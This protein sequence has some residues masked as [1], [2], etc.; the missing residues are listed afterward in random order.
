MAPKEMR[1]C[2]PLAQ[3]LVVI[4]LLTCVCHAIHF[5][6]GFTDK[7]IIDAQ[8]Q[9]VRSRRDTLVKHKTQHLKPAIEIEPIN[10]KVRVAMP[11][12]NVQDL[13]TYANQAAAAIATRFDDF[14]P[15]LL[16]SNDSRLQTSSAA[17]F[18]AAS[19][20]TKVVA[21][22][23]SRIALMAEEATKYFAQG[24]KLTK[25]QITFALPTMD[26]RN[27]VLA[28]QCPLEVDFPCQPRKYRAY[29]GYCNNVQNP[30]WGNAN[31]RYLRFLPPD[32]SDGVSI[33]RQASDG[34]FLPSARDISLA[35]HKDVDNPHLHLTAMAAIWGQLVHNDISHTPQMAGF[36]GQRLRCCGVNLHEFHP[37]CYPIRLPDTDPVN[38]QINIKCQEYVRSGTAPRVG[39]TLGPREQINQVTSFMDGSTIYGSSVEEAND[40]RLFRAGLMKT[41]PGPAGTTKGLLPPDDNII[42]CNTKNKDV[43]CFKAGDV[44]VN[45]H[46]ELTALHVILI[47]EHNRLAEELAVINSH[48]SDETLFQEAR[49]I[50][51]AEMQHITYSEFLPVIL[52]QTIMEKYGLEPEFSGYF[53]G[54]DIN[55]NPG[56]ANSVAA[57]ALRF[58]ASLLP[59]KMGLYRNGRKI[60]EQKMGSSFYAP[61][62]L[63]EPNGLD[64]I[65]E[66][67]ARTLSQSEDPSINDVMTNHMFQEKP[68]TAGLDLA[69]QIIQHGRDHGIPGYIK[70]REFCG[71]PAVTTFD[72]LSDV[73]NGATIATLKSIYRHINDIDLF[74]GG[75]AES[76]NAGAVVGRTLGCL[77]GR[78]FHYLRRGD[79]YWYE[80]ELPPSSFTKDQLHA[81]R[82]VSLARL[83]CDNSDSIDQIQPRV[84]LINDPFL[85]ADMSCHD[86]V[87]PK[88]D[89][90]AWK[91]ASPHFVIP[92]TLL[93]ESV[94]RAKREA[95]DYLTLEE[96]LQLTAGKGADPKSAVGTAFSFSRP[97]RQA[98]AIANISRVLQFAS[99]RFVNSFLNLVNQKDVES[100]PQPSTLQELMKVL[101]NIDVSE[102]VDIPKVFQC[103]EQ[104]LPCDHTSKFRTMTGWC[105]NLNFPELG[106]SLRAFVRLLPPKYEDGLSTM[107]ATAVSGRPLPSARMISANIHNDVSA[108]HTRYSLMVMQYAQLLDHD[109]TFTPV[110]RGFGGSI[111]DCNSCDSAKTVHPECAP[112]SVPPNDPWFPHI[113]RTT[114]RPKCI[115]FTRSLPGQLTLGHREQ[116]NQVTAFVDGSHTYGS[117]VCEMRKL[118]AFV[119]G[120]M[121]STRHPIRGKDLLPLSSEHLEC[122][123]PSGVCFTGGDTRASE[124]PGLTSIH[125][126]FMR[127]HNRIV[128]ELAKINP[129][130]NDEQLFQNGRRI[131]GAEFQHMSYNEFLPRVLGWNAVQLYDLKV[132]TEGYYNG[133][134]ATCNPTVFTEFASAAFRFGHSLL[135]EQFKRMGANFVDRKQNVKLR[136]VFMNPDVIYQVGMIDDLMRG[137]L[138]TSMETMDQFIT[139]EVTNHLFEEK[140]KPFSGLDLAALNI[141]RARDHGIRPYNDYRALC[142]LK[143]ARTFEDLSREVTPEIITRLKQTYEHVDDID[144]FPGGLAETSLHGGLVGPTFACIIAM[145]FRQLRKCDRFWYE[146]GD[147][148]IRFT[149]AQLA[150]IRKAT[151]S[152]LICDNSDGIDTTQRSAFDQS[153][154]FLNPRVPC[155]S[156]PSI[157]LELWKERVSCTVGSTNIE[158]GKADRISPCVMCTCTRE[159]PICQ[160]LKV[161]NCF[162]LAQTFSPA[163]ILNDHVC[164]V[165]CAFAFRAFP[166]VAAAQDP[167]QLGF[168]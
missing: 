135:K 21:K 157:D 7:V 36:L 119:G 5:E 154:P 62:E 146:N 75:L 102:V 65:I 138:G 103:D 79:R 106:K 37:E 69:A 164:K 141:Q 74:T 70:W 53:T 150:E 129:H 88:M 45:E 126:M 107:R 98:S 14:E 101:P 27:T 97:K 57:S 131:M 149:E 142:N 33:P 112:I 158:V 82:K 30:R 87:I 108:P 90:G 52:G 95:E 145:Q 26:V 46:T 41:Q 113:D 68:G 118:R 20:K 104:T 160:S 148:L 130:W 165:Q 121:N 137:M 132:L 50:V 163:A 162:Q 100:Q 147:P 58:V 85:N 76:P 2:F 140:A 117:D 152:K 40:L 13:T 1:Y 63:Y 11:H 115:P 29:N 109:L 39:C 48:W 123:S 6:S 9:S 67:L 94:V 125:T 32:Y 139:H 80:N 133:Y 134:D 72:Q 42:D 167:N 105:N 161:V 128:T 18:M 31:T 22:N 168:S 116:L 23:I 12:F 54:Y 114:G 55:I 3:F 66:G 56:V 110:N 89:L 96:T 28:D 143:R 86:G 127:E 120:R 15:T 4:W 155:R 43:K 159:G 111:I 8:Q 122:K 99:K 77:I 64:E 136:D 156:L 92:E 59:K 61:F 25:E 84:F 17:W 83:V 35:V 93:E 44:R 16:A 144:L 51:G 73:M 49:R 151:V 166:Q 153:E 19:H 81:I 124:Q 24:L 78:Q 71:L 47:R 60:S 10:E 34:T 38:G 91:T